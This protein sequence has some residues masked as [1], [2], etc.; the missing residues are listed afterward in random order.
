MCGSQVICFVYTNEGSSNHHRLSLLLR[1]LP[2]RHHPPPARSPTSLIM[3]H[4]VT[5]ELV[6]LRVLVIHPVRHRQPPVKASPNPMFRHL[7]S[8]TRSSRPLPHLY[9]NNSMV[10]W[11][12]RLIL[13]QITVFLS[14]RHSWIITPRLRFD[15]HVH[16]LHR[17]LAI[18]LAQAYPLAHQKCTTSAT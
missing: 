13:N 14:L 12:P 2:S 11:L 18:S 1:L 16:N 3:K 8:V 9:T 5:G 4:P 10:N 7:C 15:T 6:M 17:D